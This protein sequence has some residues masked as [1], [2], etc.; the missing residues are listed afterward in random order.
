MIPILT[1]AAK[2]ILLKARTDSKAAAKILLTIDCP[3]IVMNQIFM[4]ANDNAFHAELKY[5]SGFFYPEVYG[6]FPDYAS[7]VNALM[8]LC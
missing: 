8:L 2:A 3:L 5:F 1:S 7:T 4:A 6:K